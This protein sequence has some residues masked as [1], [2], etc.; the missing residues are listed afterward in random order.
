M[1]SDHEKSDSEKE[2]GAL[3][4]D[5]TNGEDWFFQTHGSSDPILVV[6]N[7]DRKDAAAAQ[8]KI[9][10]A[11]RQAKRKMDLHTR[12]DIMVVPIS[13][14]IALS[15]DLVYLDP[16]SSIQHVDLEVSKYDVSPE[17]YKLI[18]DGLPND[19]GVRHEKSIL[20]NDLI[21]FDQEVS[22][23]YNLDKDENLDSILLIE[24]T[25]SG[26][27]EFY[28]VVEQQSN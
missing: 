7:Q 28:D 8:K 19:G 12:T 13:S 4:Q 17:D 6:N 9:E 25:L 10:V 2:W 22:R 24:E 26:N 5:I 15:R 18:K 21:N 1:I 16:G 20:D 23:L 11:L 14:R 27:E 3:I